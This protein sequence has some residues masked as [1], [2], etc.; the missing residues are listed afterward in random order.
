MRYNFYLVKLMII[1]LII[2]WAADY[3]YS[4]MIV[5]HKKSG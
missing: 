3:A 2:N 4:S 1:S 5:L